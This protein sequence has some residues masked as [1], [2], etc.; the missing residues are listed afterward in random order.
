MRAEEMWG[1]S[2]IK[3]GHRRATD[4]PGLISK[5]RIAAPQSRMSGH[6]KR[7]YRKSGGKSSIGIE[8]ESVNQ[9]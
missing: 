6:Y 9:I 1:R 3:S 2:T 4:D 5:T 8:S 7:L